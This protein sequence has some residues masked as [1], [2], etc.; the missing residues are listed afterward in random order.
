ML[1]IDIADFFG[2]FQHTELRKMLDQRV[3]DG[4]IRRTINKWLNAGVM[5]DGCLKYPEAGSP[6][7][8]LCKASHNAPYAKKVVMQS[9]PQKTK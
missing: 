6:Q 4:V 3:G 9:N 1:E 7:G 8:G 2:T 5:E